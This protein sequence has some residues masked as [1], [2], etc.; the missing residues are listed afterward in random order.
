ME[1][2]APGNGTYG[3]TFRAKWLNRN[4]GNH[5]LWVMHHLDHAD[6]LLKEM[7]VPAK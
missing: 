4:Q 3:G 7:G 5:L 6:N 1:P 2:A